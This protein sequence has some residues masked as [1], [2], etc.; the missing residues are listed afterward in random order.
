[1]A[2]YQK[3]KS[4]WRAQVARNGVRTSATFSTK[5]EAT[6]WAA[7]KE[8]EILD[9]KRGGYPKKTLSD[10]IERYISE[11]SIK[12]GGYKFERLRLY[13][14]CREFPELVSMQMSEIDNPDIVKWRNKRM[15]QVSPGSVQR[16]INLLSNVFAVA[17][18]EW[19]WRGE[20]P[21]K[22]VWRP[23]DNAPRTRRV[24][25]LE[26]RRITRGLGYVTGKV[27]T[28]QQEVALA[29]L[30]SLRTGMRA[31]EILSLTDARV[32]LKRR[33]ASVPHKMKYVTKTDRHIPLTK[34]AV[35]LLGYVAGRGTLF[36]VKGDS[37]DAL[38]R[39]ARDRLM[40][41][42]LHFH[43]AR[44]EALTRLARKVDVMTLA[45]ISGHSDLRVLMQSYYRESAEDIAARLDKL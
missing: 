2:Y 23:G 40:I 22:G 20:S 25:P 32:D 18:D 38:F 30:L 24:M 44:A 16:E 35:R 42:G 28:K 45:K 3:H 19:R 26:V 34:A 17:R 14:L 41:E 21:F 9:T 7:Q 11:V 6:A 43:D 1:M 39:K 37:L 33:V 5:A 8:A 15:E 12:K 29:F 36:S 10:A 31:G 13:A 4:G 27:R